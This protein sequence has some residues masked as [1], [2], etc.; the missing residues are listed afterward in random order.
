MTAM[1]QTPATLHARAR[2]LSAVH[3]LYILAI[4]AQIII[5][6]SGKLIPPEVVLQRWLATAAFAAVVTG[7]WYASRDATMKDETAKKL[8]GSLVVADI[9]LASFNVYTQRG[10]ASRAVMLYAIPIVVAAAINRRS[11][12]I[13]SSL[14]S[15]AAYLATCVA[16]FVLHFNEGYK[17]ELYGEAGFYAAIFIILS[18]SLWSVIKPKQ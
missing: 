2:R 3:L 15:A 12:I 17:L 7:V 18:L 14:L 6:D 10:M 11:A 9:A 16:Y 13:A 1:K 4:I 8:I 5:F